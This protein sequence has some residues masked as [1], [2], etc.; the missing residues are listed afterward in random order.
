MEPVIKTVG[1]SRNFG[2]QRAVNELTLEIHQGEI[3]GFLGHN[4]AGKTT[5]VRLLNGVLAPTSGSAIV[6]GMKPDT[7]GHDLRQRTGVLTETPALDERLSG[8]ENLAIYADLYNVPQNTKAERIAYLLDVFALADRAQDKA[9][10]YSKGMKQRLALAR[11]MLHNP[12]ILFLDEPTAALDPVGARQVHDM[13]LR[14][15]HEEGRTIFLCTHNLPEAQRLCDRIGVMEHGRLIAL[16]K[17]EELAHEAGLTVG[18]EI[19]VAE[20]DR[21]VAAATLRT[22]YRNITIDSQHKQLSISGAKPNLI[23]EMIA[24]LVQANVRIYRVSPQDASLEDIYF[25]L[26]EK[27]QPS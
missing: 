27:V 25:A 13:I 3:F 6:L 26:H 12:E 1:L 23:P 4:G 18:L 22:H 9:A 10:G 24:Q 2:D 17:T 14:L 16:G 19:E 7:Q 8:Y 20:E 21:E 5:T 15:S 11:S